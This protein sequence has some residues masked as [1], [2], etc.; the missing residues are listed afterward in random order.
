[1]KLITPFVLGLSA[2]LPAAA[3]AAD[4]PGTRPNI[5]FFIADDLSLKDCAAMFGPGMFVGP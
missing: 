5:V 3:R 4:V 2:L 1:M